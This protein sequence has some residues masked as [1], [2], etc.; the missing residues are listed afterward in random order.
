MNEINK[1]IALLGEQILANETYTAFKAAEKK[2][3]EDAELSA[4]VNAFDACRNDLI[5]ARSAQT[6]DEAAITSI[7][8]RME[9]LYNKI[10]E[11]E[12]MKVYNDAAGAFEALMKQVFDGINTAVS[13]PQE[14]T[15]N[16]ATCSGCH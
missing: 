11:N 3:Q 12:N 13:G 1:T 15:H 6:P 8:D 7:Q 4:L 9:E 10:M 2:Y 16:C 14:C 5:M